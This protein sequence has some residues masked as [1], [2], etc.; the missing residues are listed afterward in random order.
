[1]AVDELAELPGVATADRHG[2]SVLLVCS[3]SDAAIRA[4]LDR[5][6]AARDIE[7]TGAG[8][9]DAFIQLTGGDAGDSDGAA[10]TTA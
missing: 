6:D 3:D 2:E 10:R 7:V 8:L 1:V 5:H 9:E 4:L